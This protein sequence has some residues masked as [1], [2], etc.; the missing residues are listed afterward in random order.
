[1]TRLRATDARVSAG[2]AGAADLAAA[3]RWSR[4][5][6]FSVVVCGASLARLLIG[7]SAPRPFGQLALALGFEFELRAAL[8]LGFELDPAFG[9]GLGLGA[10]PCGFGEPRISLGVFALPGDYQRFRRKLT[11]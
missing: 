10:S 1:M 3:T 7:F 2:A 11:R 9:L 5:V 8:L 4:V 6:V